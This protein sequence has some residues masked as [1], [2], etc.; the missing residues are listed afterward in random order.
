M[1]AA[2]TLA[3][4][5]PSAQVDDLAGLI[6]GY[7][8]FE[9]GAVEIV[10]GRILRETLERQESWVWLHVDL[11]AEWARSTI[12]ALPHLPPPVIALL[13]SDDERQ[14]IETYGQVICG[15]VADYER[16]QKLDVRRIVR[17]QFAMTP[18]LFISA[19]RSPGH[20]LHQVHANLQAGRTFPDVVALFTAIIH[21]FTSAT[22]LLM[23]GV[24]DRLDRMEEQLFDHGEVSGP[25]ALGAVRRELVRLRS[26]VKPLRAV[27]V[28]MLTEPPAWFDDRIAAE[29]RR[30]TDRIESLVDDLESLQE[31]A[32]ALNDELN[33]RE[34][35]QINKRLT[36]LSVV[37]A[38]LL[39][40]TFLTGVF[41][42]N[43]G[44]LP[45]RGTSFG[46]IDTCALMVIS[47]AAMLVL[48]RRLRLL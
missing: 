22:A 42:M 35:R 15:V 31:R 21:E 43:V 33:G 32:N 7:R 37:S 24:A 5:G 19:R 6:W 3:P 13:L 48:L 47:I 20:T 44:G 46:F 45:W 4:A 16:T 9:G 34:S 36:L 25:E 30:T 12:A 27:L 40:P 26:Q 29:G 18:C 8:F 41:G 11:D 39:P 10:Q 17:W 38:L 23:H 14:H 1:T 28:H 2:E